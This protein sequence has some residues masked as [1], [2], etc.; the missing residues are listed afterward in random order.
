MPVEYCWLYIVSC[1][2]VDVYCVH[3]M[4]K[5]IV[6]CAWMVVCVWL[7]AVWRIVLVVYWWCHIV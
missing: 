7:C 6:V 5:Y 3:V 4:L 1:T 2:V